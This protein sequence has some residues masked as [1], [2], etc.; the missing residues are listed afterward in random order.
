[1]TTL[2]FP[3]IKHTPIKFPQKFTYA[4]NAK[5]ISNSADAF[6]SVPKEVTSSKMG[7]AKLK[8]LKNFIKGL[9]N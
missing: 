6:I 3:P 4:P 7:E 1:M 2:K 8:S 5:A 9:F